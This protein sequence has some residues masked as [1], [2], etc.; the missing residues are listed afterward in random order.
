MLIESR[1]QF[2]P[3]VCYID[4]AYLRYYISNEACFEHYNAT[5]ECSQDHYSP[6]L[7][8]CLVLTIMH[9]KRILFQKYQFPFDEYQLTFYSYYHPALHLDGCLRA[10]QL[11]HQS[12]AHTNLLTLSIICYLQLTCIFDWFLLYL[13]FFCLP[14]IYSIM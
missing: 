12:S 13:L 3:S 7:N 14:K 4:E 5:S 8:G 10:L 2:N 6:T 9:K 1:R 11:R